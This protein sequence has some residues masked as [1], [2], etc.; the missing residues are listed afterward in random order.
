MLRIALVTNHLPAFQV[1]ATQHELPALYRAAGLPII[2][3]PH[4]GVAGELVVDGENGFICPLE[5]DLWIDRVS[6]LRSNEALYRRF[7][8]RSAALVSEYTFDRAATG[9]VDACRHAGGV[10]HSEKLNEAGRRCG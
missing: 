6:L 10:R 3:S 8:R 1:H 9:I 5:R 7:S 2:V 4:A